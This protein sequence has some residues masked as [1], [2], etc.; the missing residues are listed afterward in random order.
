MAVTTCN[1]KHTIDLPMLVYNDL[2]HG[3]MVDNKEAETEDPS[4][5]GGMSD[6]VVIPSNYPY[7]YIPLLSLRY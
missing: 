4:T 1:N 5:K 3:K 6:E 7:L 2:V